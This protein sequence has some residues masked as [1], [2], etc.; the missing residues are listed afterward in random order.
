MKTVAFIIISLA[1]ILGFS[2]YSTAMV[3]KQCNEF[4][5]QLD[6]IAHMIQ[7]NE[8]ETASVELSREF[9]KWQQT[10]KTWHTLTD[11]SDIDLID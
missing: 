11:H 9:D 7:K 1:L 10:R 8:W 4:L 5:S 2:I 3:E 6:E